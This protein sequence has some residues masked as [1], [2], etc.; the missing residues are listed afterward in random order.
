MLQCLLLL[1][2]GKADL[3][4]MLLAID[5]GD[6]G[7]VE[8]L[9]DF[10]ADVAGLESKMFFKHGIAK[11]HFLGHT[12]RNQRHGHCLRCLGGCGSSTLCVGRR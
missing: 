9:D 12:E 7:V 10:V 2:V 3:D 11:Y 8:C 6:G 4:Q 5:F 1:G